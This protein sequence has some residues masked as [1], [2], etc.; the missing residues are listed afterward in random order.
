LLAFAEIVNLSVARL[1]LAVVL[2]ARFIESGREERVFHMELEK[3]R[4]AL[5]TIMPRNIP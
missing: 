5:D 2:N 3:M 1:R 4:V